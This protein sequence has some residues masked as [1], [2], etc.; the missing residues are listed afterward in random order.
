MKHIKRFL[1]SG[2]QSFCEC[3]WLTNISKVESHETILAQ[4]ASKLL[5]NIMFSGV[6]KLSWNILFN[7]KR[8]KMSIEQMYVTCS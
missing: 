4:L 2:K 7:I 8:Y 6:K 3:S 1:I 5:H